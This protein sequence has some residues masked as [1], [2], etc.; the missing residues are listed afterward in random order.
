MKI[1]TK[2]VAIGFTGFAAIIAADV[3]THS[4]VIY[5]AKDVFVTAA[6]YFVGLLCFRAGQKSHTV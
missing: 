5:M 3:F 1:N 6:I 4:T 2:V